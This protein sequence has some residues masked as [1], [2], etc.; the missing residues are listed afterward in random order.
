MFIHCLSASRLRWSLLRKWRS[1]C[2]WQP[3]CLSCSLPGTRSSCMISSNFTVSN[4]SWFPAV[5]NYTIFREQYC[6][7]DPLIKNSF[8]WATP[9]WQ[10]DLNHQVDRNW[11]VIVDKWLNLLNRAGRIEDFL[12]SFDTVSAVRLEGLDRAGHV[13]PAFFFHVW[14]FGNPASIKYF[15]LPESWDFNWDRHPNKAFK[16]LIVN[17]L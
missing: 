2:S 15:S 17:Y 11:A 16:H 12:R 13:C 14:N 9:H 4:K 5:K 1:C 6:S 3:V 7:M 8:E 10:L